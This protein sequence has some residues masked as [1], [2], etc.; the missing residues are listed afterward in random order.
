[1]TA[2]GP[3]LREEALGPGPLRGGGGEEAK[4]KTSLS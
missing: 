3:E 2:L 1:M 4:D